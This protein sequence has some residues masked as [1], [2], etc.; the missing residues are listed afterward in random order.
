MDLVFQ[1]TSVQV[2][3]WNHENLIKK[4]VKKCCPLKLNRSLDR[5]ISIEI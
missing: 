1:E 3:Y 4:Q 2:K 5:I